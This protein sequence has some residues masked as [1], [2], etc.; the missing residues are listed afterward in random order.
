MNESFKLRFLFRLSQLEREKETGF[1][2]LRRVTTID[3]RE[4]RKKA[5]FENI[6]IN[7]IELLI[8]PAFIEE[9]KL[10]EL[11]LRVVKS[12]NFVP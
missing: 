1:S 7:P 9:E 2:R 4:E 11:N 3:T 12:E 10:K 5:L 8:P 6:L